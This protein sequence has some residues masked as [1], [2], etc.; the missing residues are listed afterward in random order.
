MDL[1]LFLHFWTYRWCVCINISPA[2]DS[3]TQ[4][5]FAT[6]VHGLQ[7]GALISVERLAFPPSLCAHP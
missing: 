2:V 5:P 4:I 1:F 3:K 6:I 7:V